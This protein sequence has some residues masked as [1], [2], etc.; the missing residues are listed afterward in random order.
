M[1]SESDPRGYPRGYPRGA[2]VPLCLL[3]GEIY[4]IPVDRVRD[5]P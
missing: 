1:I 3:R 4:L 2:S 5:R